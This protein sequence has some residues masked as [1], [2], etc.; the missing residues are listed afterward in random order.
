MRPLRL[1]EKDQ[2]LGAI[3]D[4]SVWVRPVLARKTWAWR[5]LWT[6]TGKEIARFL[7]IWPQTVLAPLVMTLVLYVVVSSGA[8]GLARALDEGSFL[9]FL[10]AGLIMMAAAQS[11]FMTPSSSLVLAKLQGHVVDVLMAPLAPMEAALAYTISGL[12]RGVVVG[13][14]AWGVLALLNGA[15]IV[16]AWPAAFFL[17]AGALMLSL[18]GVI[19]GVLSEKFDHIGFMQNFIIMPAV[20]LSGSFFSLSQMPD[21]WRQACFVNPF[22]YMIDGFRYAL[23]GF[24]DVVP[25][26]AAGML[27]IVC[28]ILSTIVYWLFAAGTRLRT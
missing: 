22:F 12:V 17:F 1:K 20:F 25:E 7:K 2:E 24:S 15:G 18:M 28:L 9:P 21:F 11:A 19:T 10:S 13:I 5:G 16:H 6:L 27:V 3:S 23:T 4:E 14:A 26:A 8:G